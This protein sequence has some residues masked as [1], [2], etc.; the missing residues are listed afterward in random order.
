MK[1]YEAEDSECVMN[2]TT[3]TNMQDVPSAA[4]IVSTRRHYTHQPLPKSAELTSV[5]LLRAK[6][7][8]AMNICWGFTL[9]ND[10]SLYKYSS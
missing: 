2:G 3:E 1:I 8:R 5:F 9:S 6:S 7:H 4:A 10:G